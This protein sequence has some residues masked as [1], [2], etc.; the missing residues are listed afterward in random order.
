[1]IY[2]PYLEPELYQG[3]A[4]YIFHIAGTQQNVNPIPE[5]LSQEQHWIELPS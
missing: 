5:A 3:S 2:K 4:S 1:M